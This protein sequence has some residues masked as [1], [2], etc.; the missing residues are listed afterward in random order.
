MWSPRSSS[1]RQRELPERQDQF[2]HALDRVQPRDWIFLRSRCR[3]LLAALGEGAS[4]STTT[5]NLG[6]HGYGWIHHK[7][8]LGT[9]CFLKSVRRCSG[10][11]RCSPAVN[12]EA[13]E[14]ATLNRR[15]PCV[16][17]QVRKNCK[18]L[19]VCSTCGVGCSS[20]GK[21]QGESGSDTQ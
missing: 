13:I 6:R 18:N 4:T 9:L 20:T 17:H 19:P 16:S 5:L 10:P 2:L 7:L 15:I 8:M 1:H 21:R 12:C 11:W 14:Y 3:Q